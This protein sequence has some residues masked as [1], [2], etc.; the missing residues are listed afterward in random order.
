M[1]LYFSPLACSMATRIA[2]YELGVGAE[3]VQVNT[4]KQLTEA[5]EDFRAVN[6]LGMT[7]GVAGIGAVC[8]ARRLAHDT[9]RS[10]LRVLRLV[11]ED[12]VVGDQGRLVVELP[13]LGARF[14]EP[15][16]R[17]RLLCPTGIH[18]GVLAT[19][20]VGVVIGC[21]AR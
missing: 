19:K 7:I 18:V 17:A 4:K 13:R 3:Y 11:E 10:L 16:H 8:R 6:S 14:D 21:H 2:L 5:G 20:P 15:E 9:H 12:L 1:K